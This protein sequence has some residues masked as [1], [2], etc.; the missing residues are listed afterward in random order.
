M[1]LASIIGLVVGGLSILGAIITA[2]IWNPRKA[3]D[4]GY[5]R[6]EHTVVHEKLREDVD[7]AHEKIRTLDARVSEIEGTNRQIMGK[8]EKLDTI[9]EQVSLITAHLLGKEDS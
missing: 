9:G 2:T 8:L 3:T 4:V 7:S 1:S 6:G 5:A